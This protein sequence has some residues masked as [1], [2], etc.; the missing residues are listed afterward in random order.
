[1]KKTLDEFEKQFGGGKIKRLERELEIER[2]KVEVLADVQ[3]KIT[4]L[5]TKENT[6][7]FGLIGDT[8]CCLGRFFR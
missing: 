7:K 2:R 6:F 4:V 8:R 1:M 3:Y 5:K